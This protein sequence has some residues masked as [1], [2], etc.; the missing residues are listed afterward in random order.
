MQT[1]TVSDPIAVVIFKK[2]KVQFDYT[3]QAWVVNGTYQTCGHLS[4]TCG[5]YGKLHAGEAVDYTQSEIE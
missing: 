1:I 5:C 4:A 3:N 2:D